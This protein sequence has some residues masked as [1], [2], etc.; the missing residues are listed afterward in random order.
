V[1]TVELRHLRAF[2]AVAR[3]SS[4]TKA[5]AELNYAQ[6]SITEQVKALETD[7]GTSLF[8]RTGRKL[9]LTSAGER[10]VDYAAQVLSLVDEARSV[11]D[12]ATGELTGELTVGGLETLC[13]HRIPAVLVRY[14]DRFPQVRVTVCEGNRGEM[15]E[16]V[17]RGDIDVSFTFG[18]PPTDAVFA[19]TV[20]SD[21]RLVVATPVGHRLSAK[22]RVTRADLRDEPFLATQRGCGFREMFDNALGGSDPNGPHLQAEVASIAAL[23][24]CVASGM[25]LALLPEMVADGPAKRGEIVVLPV[26]ELDFRVSVTMT[27]LRRRTELA[28]LAGFLTVAEAA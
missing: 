28:Q 20:H 14:Q 5:A 9:R 2:Q 16:G 1:A 12:S 7:L 13:A 26:A 6:S 11:V 18:T 25:G 23:C 19:S 27:W 21:D 8:D 17:R 4:F 10:M 24:A 15:Y 22:D 3:T